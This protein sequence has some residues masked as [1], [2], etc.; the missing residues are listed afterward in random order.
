VV[1]LSAIPEFSRT[2]GWQAISR[3]LEADNDRFDV[4]REQSTITISCTHLVG[5]HADEVINIFALA[6]R[7]D[8]TTRDLEDAVFAYPTACSDIH[9][10][11]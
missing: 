9:Y 3:A 6:I 1:T 4:A 2:L 7:R 10:M 11:L 5:P 8:L